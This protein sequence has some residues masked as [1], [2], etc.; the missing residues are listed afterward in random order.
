MSQRRNFAYQ[1]LAQMSELGTDGETLLG[2]NYL[3]EHE[4]VNDKAVFDPGAATGLLYCSRDMLE[5]FS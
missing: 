5:F 2:E 4:M 3:C 1:D